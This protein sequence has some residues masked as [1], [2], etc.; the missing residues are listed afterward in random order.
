MSHTRT[1]A[2]E[3]RNQPRRLKPNLRAQ[4]QRAV[5]QQR[6]AGQALRERYAD[7]AVPA[8]EDEGMYRP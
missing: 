7:A 6:L 2:P 5:Q 8:P 4:A 1:R 3:R